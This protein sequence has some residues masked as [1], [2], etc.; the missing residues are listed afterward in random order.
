[1]VRVAAAAAV[2]VVVVVLLVMVAVVW[3]AAAAAAMPYSDRRNTA[4]S[5]HA[6]FAAAAF[7]NVNAVCPYRHLVRRPAPA[8]PP[9]HAIRTCGPNGDHDGGGG[10]GGGRKHLGKRMWRRRRRRRKKAPRQFI[11]VG[12]KS[13]QADQKLR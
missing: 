9:L 12:L 10:G 13:A 7:A 6:H 5:M 11:F 8:A 3:S 4:G 2:V 1:L